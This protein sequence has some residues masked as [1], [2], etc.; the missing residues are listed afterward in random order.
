MSKGKGEIVFTKYGP[1]TVVDTDI[2]DE[3]GNKIEIPRV[4]SLCRCGE[5][6]N[7]PFCDGSH[8]KV[9]F[10]GERE[11]KDV[12]GTRDYV[13]G[14]ITI[15]DNRYICCHHGTCNMEGVFLSNTDPWIVPDGSDDIDAIIGV[16]KECPS[17]AL[18]YTIDGKHKD[19]WTEEQKIIITKDG[20]LHVEG[21]VELKDDLE[22]DDNLISRN[23]YALCRCGQSKNKPFCDG[24]HI[25]IEFKG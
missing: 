7:K 23:H 1:Y 8:G 18:S 21:S 6:E 3:E 2:L 16:V 13:G 14:K 25:D 12:N 24:S 20:P 19:S 9:G 17:G 11:S 15:H 10:I 22:S 5:S 4:V